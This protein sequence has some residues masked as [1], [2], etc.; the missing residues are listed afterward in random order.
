MK[1]II[2]V[3]VALA[4]FLALPALA[5]NA[6]SGSASNA[7]NTANQVTA[8]G[9]IA[10]GGS[11]VNNFPDVP[12]TQTIRQDGTATLKTAPSLGG[13]AVGGGHPCA[14]TP[15][16]GQISLIGG[17]LGGA[18]MTI[19]EACMLAVMG[20]A[21]G[22][23]QMHN[24]ALYIIAARDPDACKAM[25]MAGLVTDCVDK[26]GRSRILPR[27]NAKAKPVTS[28]R[29]LARPD[30]PWHECRKT[31]NNGVKIKYKHGVDKTAAK[32]RCLLTLGY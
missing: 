18:G 27:N 23:V 25:Y 17:G 16:S 21:T 14:W 32:S 28:T 10:A 6:V 13:L 8:S 7:N 15:G 3:G 9:A 22:S 26:E 20:A 30:V 11:V 31:G 2:I 1:R 4:S 29:P 24:A 19:D 12:T 5:Q